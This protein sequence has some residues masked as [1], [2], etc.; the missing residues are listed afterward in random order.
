MPPYVRIETKNGRTN[1]IYDHKHQTTAENSTVR[2]NF[3]MVL[4]DGYDLQT[5]INILFEKL[6]EKY[7]NEARLFHQ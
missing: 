5:S 7:P 2:Y 6:R 4:K 1:L 3:R